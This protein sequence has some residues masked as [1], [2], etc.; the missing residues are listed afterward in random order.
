M[1][2]LKVPRSDASNV[3]IKCLVETWNLKAYIFGDWVKKKKK[4]KIITILFLN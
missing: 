3:I 1:C 4:G 2:I